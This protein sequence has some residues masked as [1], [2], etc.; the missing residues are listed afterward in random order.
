MSVESWKAEFYPTAAD[1]CPKDEAIA[2]ALK[3][4]EGT[5]PEN[6]A[7]HEVT[8]VCNKIIGDDGKVFAFDGYSCALC[9]HYYDKATSC[10]ECPLAIS[11]KRRCDAVS[12]G[13]MSKWQ[14]ANNGNPLPMI[15]ALRVINNLTC[16][17]GRENG[18][19]EA[20]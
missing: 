13:P 19:S 14:H 6:L 12:F 5:L 4:W 3:K 20:S 18:A 11:L 8:F 1:G 17:N 9:Q 7:K 16:Q 15:E 10:E 2:H